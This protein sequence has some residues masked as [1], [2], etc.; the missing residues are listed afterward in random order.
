MLGGRARVV[1]TGHADASWVDDLATQRSSQGYTLSLGSGCV[2]WRSTRSSSVLSS[3]CEAEIYAGAMAAQEL[4]WLT[5][6]LIDLGEAPRSPPVLY[7]DNKA[8]LALCQEHR[9]EHRT[10]HIARRYFLARELQQRGQLRLA[11]VA[12]Q[13][14]NADVFTKALQPCDHQPCFVFLDWSCDLLFS[15]TLPMGAC[16]A[17]ITVG[18]SLVQ[19]ER[20]CNGDQG[21]LV[22]DGGAASDAVGEGVEELTCPGTPQQNGIAERANRTIGE[23]AKTSLGAAGMPYKFWPEAVRH[24]IMVKNRVLTYV[25]DKHWV[26][27]VCWLGKKPSIDMLRVWGYMGLVMVPKEQRHKLEVAALWSVHLGMAPDSK[28]WLMWDPKSKKTL[29]S[30]EEVQLHLEDLYGLELTSDHSGGGEQ[31][32]SGRA[33]EE[34][35]EDESA[36]VDSPSQPEP[37]ATAKV[38]K[39]SVQKGASPHGQQTATCKKRVAEPPSRLKYSRLGGPKQGAMAVQA[40]EEDDEEMAFCFSHLCLENQPHWRRH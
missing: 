32:V 9:L 6:L 24:V 10:K 22:V 8:M 26:P 27:Y 31:Q 12:S 36:R 40:D 19:E 7:V 11:Y 39:R 15:L 35:L 34:G 20:R 14:N 2:S 4:R 38:T 33:A 21:G 1:L 37:A 13:A 29:V 5:Y 28:G 16:V 23:A 3:S 17:Q 18:T 25:G 30:L